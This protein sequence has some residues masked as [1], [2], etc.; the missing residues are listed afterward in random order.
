MRMFLVILMLCVS[1]LRAT[2]P[3]VGSIQYD[4][5]SKYLAF[6]DSL[7]ERAAITAQ[8][9][10]LKRDSSLETIRNVLNWM[11][12]NLKYDAQK[13]YA[14][15]NYDDVIREKTYGGCADQG[16]VCGVL[17]KGAGIP[18]V[19]VKTMD[20]GW[21]WDFKKGRPFQSWSGHVFLEVHVDKKWMLLDPGANLIYRD[22]SPQ[23]RILPGNRFAYDKG[24]DPKAM[25]MSLQ[26]EQWKRQT[27]ACFR[28]LDESLLPVDPA[29][30]TSLRPVAFVAGNAPYYQAM[31]R[32]ADE[33]GMTVRKQFNAEYG[34]YLPQAR[35][36]VLLVET[37]GGTPIVPLDLLEKY[38]PGSGK[39][40]R[41]P[42]GVVI[43][44]K[45]TI[46]FLEFSKQLQN[47][48]LGEVKKK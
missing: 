44:D 16:I 15:R 13:A 18:A 21:I 38:F 34:T 8:A 19:W 39:G 7:G 12:R 22:Y 43:V 23:A 33:A 26:W 35:D 17:L 10:L 5:P 42:D 3:Q 47:L 4:Q 45:T 31:S 41:H 6:P 11:D 36:H 25:V 27:E 40:L 14:W 2:E 48:Q 29:G 20:V 28:H 9:S 32:M 46:V 24:N 1:S 37:H 30:G